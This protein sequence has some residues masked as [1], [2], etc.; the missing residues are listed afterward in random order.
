MMRIVDRDVSGTIS[1]QEWF[2]AMGVYHNS[3]PGMRA[4]SRNV[5]ESARIF[6]KELQKKSRSRVVDN[7]FDNFHLEDLARSKTSSV[8]KSKFLLAA[9]GAALVTRTLTAPL[10][11]LNCLLQVFSFFVSIFF[12]FF[13]KKKNRFR[14]R[15]MLDWR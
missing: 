8:P 2:N 7:G 13:Q 5:K 11:R 6:L 10:D 4:L 3:L 9:F 12:P 14:F 15:C 1:Y